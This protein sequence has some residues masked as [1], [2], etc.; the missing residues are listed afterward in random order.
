[1]KVPHYSTMDVFKTLQEGTD[2][3]LEG[4][5]SA[6]ESTKAPASVCVHLLSCRFL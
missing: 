1:M 6:Y 3:L 2:F 4:L 5:L